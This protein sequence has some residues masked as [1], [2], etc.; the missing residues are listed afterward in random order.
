MNKRRSYDVNSQCEM[1]GCYDR[2]RSKG[3]CEKHYRALLKHG[4][5]SKYK[6]PV[7]N[8]NFQ[9]IYDELLKDPFISGADIER[10]TGICKNSRDS[11]F[12]SKGIRLRELRREIVLGIIEERDRYLLKYG[13]LD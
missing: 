1:K 9:R 2:P 12:E 4:C 13:S 5:P 6:P 3:L 7:C 10:I 8:N 11:A